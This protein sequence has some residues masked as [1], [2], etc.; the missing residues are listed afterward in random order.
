RRQIQGLDRHAVVRRSTRRT[1]L[2]VEPLNL[3]PGK[4]P[5]ELLR[6]YAFGRG[7][8]KRD[9]VLVGPGIGE[10]AAV[11]AFGD[12]V[13]VLSSDPITGASGNTGWLAVHV[14]CNDL[15]AT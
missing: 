8:A 9:D 1:G 12:E 11:V 2:A 4:V 10:D 15:A 5:P 13:A 7:G 3:P 6:R 14:A